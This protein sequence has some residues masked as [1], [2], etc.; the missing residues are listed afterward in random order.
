MESEDF[1][2]GRIAYEA[3]CET[4]DWKSAVTG[5]DLPEFYSTPE[6]VRTGW[7]A[8]ARAVMDAK[9]ELLNG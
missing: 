9:A 7:I 6:A 3:Y 1:Y 8:S 5:A 2:L 4:T